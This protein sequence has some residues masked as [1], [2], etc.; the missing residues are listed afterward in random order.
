[1]NCSYPARQHIF[2][3]HSRCTLGITIS[4]ILPLILCTPTYVTI[5]ITSEPIIENTTKYTLYHTDLSETFRTDKTL[6]KINFWIYAVFIK[7]L[8]C[9]I[10]TVISSWLI[11][12]LFIAKRRKQVLRSYVCYV[13]RED[14]HSKATKPLKTER[15]AERTTKMLIAVLVLF[16]ITEFPQGIF[17]F[18][19]G[20][21]G[22]NL[23]LDC[24]QQYGAVMDILALVSGAI[25]FILYCFMNRMFRKNFGLLIRERIFGC[26]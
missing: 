19:I 9:C 4:T 17:A 10:L 8:P 3:S 24:Y 6:L 26:T 16:L 7:L 20:I 12:T 5:S 14:G 15:R 13:F 21:K 11:R 22:N 2:C 25:N 18:F 23:F 1:M